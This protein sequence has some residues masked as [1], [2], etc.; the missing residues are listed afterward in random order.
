MLDLSRKS[1]IIKPMSKPT[2]GKVLEI[3]A[4]KEL[5]S[6]GGVSV[7]GEKVVKHFRDGGFFESPM[8][9]MLGHLFHKEDIAPRIL[10]GGDHEHRLKIFCERCER[11][12]EIVARHQS[13][14]HGARV[15]D[16]V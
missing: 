3:D 13:A 14:V 1:C 9:F 12:V 7:D 10:R 4:T 16:L 2:N 5:R 6:D 15:S 11:R 8:C